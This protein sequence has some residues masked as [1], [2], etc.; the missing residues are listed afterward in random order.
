[1]PALPSSVTKQLFAK[2]LAKA[3]P[4]MVASEETYKAVAHGYVYYL[5]SLFVKKKLLRV[6]QFLEEVSDDL[7]EYA[8]HAHRKTIE[9]NDVLLLM[10]R[11]A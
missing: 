3:D 2:F 11:Y 9:R 5:K 7:K 1:M 4:S 10:K 8:T 6:Q